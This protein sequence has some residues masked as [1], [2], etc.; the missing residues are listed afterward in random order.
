MSYHILKLIGTEKKVTTI[1][2]QYLDIALDIA[3]SLYRLKK[4]VKINVSLYF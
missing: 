2:E 4:L 1:K 3:L